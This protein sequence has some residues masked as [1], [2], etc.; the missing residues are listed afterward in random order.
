M[1]CPNDT[2]PSSHDVAKDVAKDVANDVAKDVAHHAANLVAN[3][4]AKDVDGLGSNFCLQFTCF[5][6]TYLQQHTVK[7]T[8]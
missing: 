2:H 6:D 7:S 1:C 5:G 8:F 4:V 3:L